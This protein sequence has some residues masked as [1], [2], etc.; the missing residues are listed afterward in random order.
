MAVGASLTTLPDHKAW[1]H[2][3]QP[4]CPSDQLQRLNRNPGDL[5][6]QIKRVPEHLQRKAWTLLPRRMT[7]PTENSLSNLPKESV[8]MVMAIHP[9]K[10]LH[11]DNT[12]DARITILQIM[13][14]ETQECTKVNA[15]DRSDKHRSYETGLNAASRMAT[16]SNDATAGE[17]SSQRRLRNSRTMDL[18]C[19]TDSLP[20]TNLVT[21]C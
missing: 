14:A 9:R 21:K 13:P 15:A 19:S 6:S 10:K 8:G 1:L 3:A 11:P 20:Q 2:L 17:I 12:E 7:A 4:L 5:I 16:I 18:T